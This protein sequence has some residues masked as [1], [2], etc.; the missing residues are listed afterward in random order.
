LE[1]WKA[2]QKHAV[3]TCNGKTVPLLTGCQKHF[4]P[5]KFC[6]KYGLIAVKDYR[7]LCLLSLLRTY[8][9]ESK[10]TYKFFQHSSSVW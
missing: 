2:H 6:M 9:N 1:I 3:S 7:V 5:K 10:N 8:E 4:V